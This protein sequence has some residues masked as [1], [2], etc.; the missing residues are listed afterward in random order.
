[1][2]RDM[3]CIEFEPGYDQVL[4]MRDVMTELQLISPYESYIEANIKKEGNLYIN[5]IA[6][7]YV[8]GRF[9]AQSKGADLKLVVNQTAKAVA[10]QVQKWNE[11]RFKI[12]PL[13]V[14]SA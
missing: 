9:F 7:K 8:G 5:E 4:F 1:M 11:A 3:D 13:Q 2:K 10:F 12:K 14:V 6:I